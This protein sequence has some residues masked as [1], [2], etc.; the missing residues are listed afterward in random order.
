MRAITDRWVNAFN[1]GG[2]VVK[3]RLFFYGSGRVFQ[4]KATRAANLFGPLPDREERHDRVLR[5]D[6]GLAHEQHVR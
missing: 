5:Q 6:H 1:F 3:N 4:S 2:P